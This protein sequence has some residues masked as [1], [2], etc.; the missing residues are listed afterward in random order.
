MNLSIAFVLLLSDDRVYH[1]LRAFHRN[2]CTNNRCA[3]LV[4]HLTRERTGVSLL[5]NEVVSCLY[6]CDFR[7]G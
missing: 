2:G 6:I 7:T 3:A 4:K 5:Q 1:H